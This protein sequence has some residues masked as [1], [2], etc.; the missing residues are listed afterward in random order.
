MLK[1]VCK[2]APINVNTAKDPTNVT[3]GCMDTNI[4]QTYWFSR[5]EDN[6][7]AGLKTETCPK[8]LNVATCRFTT[9]WRG[10]DERTGLLQLIGGGEDWP[11]MCCRCVNTGADEGRSALHRTG[12]NKQTTYHK[13]RYLQCAVQINKHLDRE[14]LIILYFLMVLSFLELPFYFLSL[15]QYQQHF[16]YCN[17]SIIMF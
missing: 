3:F 6:K 1:Q 15:P 14:V 16:Y 12:K 5:G 17:A 13:N 11:S 7:L 4:A 8:E 9:N 2:K 10:A